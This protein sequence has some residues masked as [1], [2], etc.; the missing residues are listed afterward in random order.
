M[1]E[2][3]GQRAVVRF[4]IEIFGNGK[5]MILDRIK[6][7]I[8]ML[9]NNEINN[10]ARTLRNRMFIL[11]L[12]L[13]ACMFIALNMMLY[14]QK[15]F[16]SFDVKCELIETISG[17]GKYKAL[18][19]YILVVRNSEEEKEAEKE[20]KINIQDGLTDGNM[21]II[22]YNYEIKRVRGGF[23]TGRDEIDVV[24]MIRTKTRD[25]KIRMYKIRKSI[26]Y[27]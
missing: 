20:L 10:P 23:S 2:R 14:A 25:E 18:K 3:V 24:R 27:R 22:T 13:L 17:A 4:L 12:T 11:G 1:E 19:S 21:L 9:H 5:R 16:E 15:R 8:I 26:Y 7:Y 6:N